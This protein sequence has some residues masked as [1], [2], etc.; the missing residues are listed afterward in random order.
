MKKILLISLVL[1]GISLGWC[2]M[3]KNDFD[4]EIKIKKPQETNILKQWNYSLDCQTK[5]YSTST[6]WGDIIEES[7]IS[8]SEGHERETLYI[9]WENAKF[10]WADFSTIQDDQN[11]LIIMRHYTVSW[12]T[13]IVTI[14]K[15]SWIGFDVK[16]KWLWISGGPTSDTYIISCI[17]I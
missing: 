6:I 12:L 14:N 11:F 13:E 15:K 10:F 2:S 17:E 4:K 5:Y 16:T 1:F 8:T 3:Q 7:Y 9:N